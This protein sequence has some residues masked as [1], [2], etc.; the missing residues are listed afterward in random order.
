M[1]TNNSDQIYNV[2]G[3]IQRKHDV[4]IIYACESG[5]RTWGFESPDS[6]YDIRFLYIQ[7]L[8]KYLCV[9]E[10]RDVIEASVPI[11]NLDFSGWDL[12]KAL[13]LLGKGNPPLIEWLKSPVVYYNDF[14]ITDGLKGLSE[15]FWSPTAAVDHYYHMARNNYNQYIKDKNELW[16][17]KYFYVLRPI[18]CV[19]WIEKYSQFPPVLFNDLLTLINDTEL[20]YNIGILLR[21]KRAGEELRHGFR[22]ESISTYLDNEINRLEEYVKNVAF[23]SQP[24]RH[25]LLDDFFYEWTLK[26]TYSGSS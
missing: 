11:Y 10:K 5:S 18:L 25:G 17:K 19:N 23:K 12:K 14:K 24:K 4:Q 6:D 21:Q 7:N 13:Y 20:L 2:I 3:E 9:H 22:V 15:L 8:R 16:I 26:Y 1:K